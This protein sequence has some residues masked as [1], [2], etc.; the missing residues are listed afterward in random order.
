MAQL[1][2]AVNRFLDRSF[3][4]IQMFLDFIKQR[5]ASFCYGQNAGSTVFVFGNIAVVHLFAQSPE[6]AN[7]N[8]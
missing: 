6:I 2:V 5:Y 4:N 1:V 8:V 3:I 7:S